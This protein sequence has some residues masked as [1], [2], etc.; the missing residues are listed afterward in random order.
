MI[1]R[2]AT[3]T[4]FLLTL[5]L[6]FYCSDKQKQLTTFLE[7]GNITDERVALRVAPIRTSAK[8]ILLKKGQE[9]RILNASNTYK[10]SNKKQKDFWYQIEVLD[11]K[12]SK[13]IGW[14]YA[15]YVKT[16]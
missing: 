16:K 8:I 5:F 2:A 12:T 13:V 3:T 4:L 1:R 9:V 6:L 10:V 7:K 14:V 11:G 15:L